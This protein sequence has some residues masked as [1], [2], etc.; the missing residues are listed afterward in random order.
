LPQAAESGKLVLKRE[1]LLEGRMPEQGGEETVGQRM[2]I[3]WR[4]TS[5]KSMGKGKAG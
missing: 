1:G 5:W 4:E 2:D 3:P